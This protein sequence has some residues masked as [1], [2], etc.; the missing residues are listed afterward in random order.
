MRLLLDHEK[1]LEGSS[2]KR[3]LDAQI[4]RKDGAWFWSFDAFSRNSRLRE[5]FSG[6]SLHLAAFMGLDKIVETL[7]DEGADLNA[8]NELHQTPLMYALLNEHYRVM[9]ILLDAKV[10]LSQRD[11]IGRTAAWF[12]IH[13][14]TTFGLVALKKAG[15]DF[16]EASISTNPWCNT[17]CLGNAIA[18]GAN[19]TVEFFLREGHDPN[20]GGSRSPLH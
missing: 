1:S 10:D 17:S 14:R 11:D 12:A 13:P 2:A 7:R 15:A 18:M 16:S 6:T 4:T 3:V 8:I 9:E 5:D 19:A 20:E